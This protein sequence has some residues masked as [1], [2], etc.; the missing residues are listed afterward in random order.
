MANFEL[1][2]K[3]LDEK[4]LNYASRTTENGD[5][6]IDLPFDGKVIKCFFSGDKF[7]SIYL[8]FE[9]IPEE[10]L[11]D[12]IFLCNELNAKYKW[13]TFYVD[14]EGDLVIHDDAL[15]SGDSAAEECFELII[16]ILDI[17]NKCK[18]TIMKCIYA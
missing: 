5:G 8:V 15:I 18:P 6:I 2:K 9:K 13:A 3:L 4:S 10:K 17:A 16:R 14:K 7:L 1:F 11:A 12:V